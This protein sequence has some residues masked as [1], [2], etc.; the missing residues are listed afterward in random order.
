LKNRTREWVRIVSL[1]TITIFNFSILPTPSSLQFLYP[2][3][4]WNDP[5]TVYF[6]LGLKPMCWDSNPAKTHGTWFQGLIKLILDVLSQ[7]EFSER[8]RVRFS[9]AQFSCS[10]M[11]DS[12]RPHGLQHTRLPCPSPTPWTYSNSCPLSWWCHPIYQPLS[13]PFPSTFNLS[14]HQDLF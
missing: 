11:S 8:Q 5:E 4:F 9:S 6:R 13:S 2:H 3:T 14:Q 1:L 12:S 7:K 10:V